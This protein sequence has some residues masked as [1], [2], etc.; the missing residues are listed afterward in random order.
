MAA[1]EKEKTVATATAPQQNTNNNTGEKVVTDA[2][3]QNGNSDIDESLRY[4]N[5]Y[6][7]SLEKSDNKPLVQPRR[8]YIEEFTRNYSGYVEDKDTQE[9]R[10]RRERRDRRIAALTDGIVALGNIT[11]AAFG[12]TPVQQTSLSKAVNDSIEKARAYRI[13]N[14]KL[15]NLAMQHAMDAQQKEDKSYYDRMNNAEDVAYTRKKDAI[16]MQLKAAKI[17]ADKD[18]YAATDAFNREKFEEVKKRNK[19]KDNRRSSGGG[20]R[21]SQPRYYGNHNG[22]DYKTKADYDSAVKADARAL[23]VPTETVD[24]VTK[25]KRPR[26]VSDIKADVDKKRNWASSL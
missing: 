1:E 10:E 11:G 5:D 6:A 24:V 2:H 19:L 20:R 4:V 26:S 25:A 16:D 14:R 12:A 23:G 13:N 21:G 9:Q 15:Y 17:K 22:R 3:V 18:R 8:N 7:K